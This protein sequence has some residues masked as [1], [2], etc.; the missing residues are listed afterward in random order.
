M[1][2]PLAPV[3]PT[4]AICL[5][6]GNHMRLEIEKFKNGK[7]SRLMFYCDTCKYGHELSMQHVSGTLA[8]YVAPKEPEENSLALAKK[9]SEK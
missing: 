7:V 1:A 4:D 6:C 5:G 8:P 3:V 2:I 9:G